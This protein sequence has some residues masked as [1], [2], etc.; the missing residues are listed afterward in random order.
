[1][2]WQ[3]REITGKG[4]AEEPSALTWLGLVFPLQYTEGVGEGDT[5]YYEYPY[6]EDPDDTE[7]TEP[8]TAKPVDAGEVTETKEVGSWERWQIPILVQL[9]DIITAC[10]QIFLQV[11]TC[12]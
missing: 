5:Y 9:F 4:L 2:N 1:M 12:S 3:H 6:Y 7:K 11:N 10:Y 8:P